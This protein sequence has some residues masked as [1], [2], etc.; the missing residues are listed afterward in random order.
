MNLL[1]RIGLNNNFK[2][3][4]GAGEDRWS[5]IEAYLQLVPPPASLAPAPDMAQSALS[6]FQLTSS[7]GVHLTFLQALA[8]AIGNKNLSVYGLIRITTQPV[9][10]A[11]WR[12]SFAELIRDM[13]RT[14]IADVANL[15]VL[16]TWEDKLDNVID[17]VCAHCRD[18]GKSIEDTVLWFDPFSRRYAGGLQQPPYSLWL[19]S[20]LTAVATIKNC[21][22]I[23]TP[24]D[25]PFAL[26]RLWCVFGI[27]SFKVTNGNFAVAMPAA[28]EELFLTSMKT[29]A[30]VFYDKLGRVS[31]ARARTNDRNDLE[32][33]QKA[34][35][36]TSSFEELDRLVVD[37]IGETAVLKLRNRM[38]ACLAV[39]N[40]VGG[41]EWQCVL[42]RLFMDRARYSESEIELRQSL[43]SLGQLLGDNSALT[44]ETSYHL[45]ILYQTQ[46][47][48]SKALP[49]L[50]DARER[51]G[52]LEGHEDQLYLQITNSLAEVH[53]SLGDSREAEKLFSYCY[54]QRKKVF[55]E[56]DPVTLDSVASLALFYDKQKLDLTDTSTFGQLATAPIVEPSA[57]PII[58]QNEIDGLR[59]IFFTAPVNLPPVTKNELK[60]IYRKKG[61]PTRGIRLSFLKSFIQECGGRD[62]FKSLST[63]D[64]SRI[65][66]QPLTSK[67][68]KS[69]CSLLAKSGR[70]DCIGD[71]TYFISHAWSYSFLNVTDAI[72]RFFNNLYGSANEKDMDD[73][74]IWFDLFSNSQ[75]GT[76]K[77]QFEWWET[78]FMEAIREIK[79]V[80]MVLE[81]W[82]K[83]ITLTRVWC[84]FEIF[85]CVTVN[86]QFH[87]AMT[88]A[89]SRR[90]AEG[91]KGGPGAF[92]AQLRQLS[93]SKSEATIP[94]DKINIFK[95]IEKNSSFEKLDELLFK[96]FG[97]WMLEQLRLFLESATSDS[98]V[99]KWKAS[100]SQLYS[101]KGVNERAQQLYVDC[102]EQRLELLG[103]RDAQTLASME[104][105]AQLYANQGQFHKAE[106]LLR[107]CF[108]T[109]RLVQGSNHPATQK[110]N[111]LMGILHMR[112]RNYR[113]A[114]EVLTDVLTRRKIALRNNHPDILL[115]KSNLASV[116]AAEAEF[117]QAEQLFLEVLEAQKE[118]LG[119]MH[120]E[121]LKTAD[122]L[123]AIY[124]RTLEKERVEP[125]YE[126]RLQVEKSLNG[127]KHPATLRAANALAQYLA[128]CGGDTDSFNK[129]R[130][131]ME[132]C[133]RDTEELVG[134]DHPSSF[135]MVE[136]IA[137]FFAEQD[138]QGELAR[139]YFEQCLSR[140]R[141]ALGDDHPSTMA[142]MV[143]LADQCKKMGDLEGALKLFEECA[144]LSF[145]RK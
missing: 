53:S 100:I 118:E 26:S 98:E 1:A 48:P 64:V 57:D 76:E 9:P 127:P 34:I 92:Y 3:S 88:A 43:E 91:I 126:M 28:E 116:Y 27:Y 36:Q 68:K 52:A 61:I 125:L 97:D 107:D 94:T 128:N 4:L 137:Q 108:I 104:S 71:A 120:Q 62:A 12:G 81:P 95:V 39:G 51:R 35:T 79:N 101:L 38:A 77:Q 49:L 131:L 31:T 40:E 105:L 145:K 86:G 45:A 59:S 69:F 112:M 130:S 44:I 123:A 42:G 121:T 72:F 96:V 84:V 11:N 19:D 56:K 15:Y 20:Y 65:F 93:C 115:C 54:E 58:S 74:I 47:Q 136:Q 16:C 55:G 135:A 46:G 37:V 140:K 113:Q 25:N 70:H 144:K 106:P 110:S 124:S 66:V 50:L 5:K 87:V 143:S 89:E 122:A 75:H 102:Y 90:F 21:V 24:W 82:D 139:E 111:F 32:K 132:E 80:V 29:N 99:V 7:V 73:T 6:D 8:Q 18:T 142:S 114:K 133:L 138:G 33:I 23:T 10:P 2:G 63:N 30:G 134:Q 129:A 141:E 13:G 117:M 78:T 14:D 60:A 67:Y 83:P 103:P 22:L 109:R 17:A 41:A 85:S 119:E